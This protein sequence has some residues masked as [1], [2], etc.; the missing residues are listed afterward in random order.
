MVWQW[1]WHPKGP[2]EA[3]LD[4]LVCLVRL[5]TPHIDGAPGS[6]CGREAPTTPF[7]LTCDTIPLDTCLVT[8]ATASKPL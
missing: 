5:W 6:M 7:A 4:S 1:N 8:E 2:R 3:S